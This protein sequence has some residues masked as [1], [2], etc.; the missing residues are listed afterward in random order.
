[1]SQSNVRDFSF[2]TQSQSFVTNLGLGMRPGKG[3]YHSLLGLLSN[4]KIKGLTF[5][6][7]NIIGLQTSSLPTSHSPSLLQSLHFTFVF[8][9]YDDSWVADIIRH[10]PHLVD[11]RLGV[12]GS[13]G[14]EVPKIDQAIGS[15]SKLAVLHR[16][17]LHEQSNSPSK[18]KNDTTPFGTVALRELVEFGLLYPPGPNG[19]LESAIRRSSDI[20]EVLILQSKARTDFNLVEA[21]GPLST[22]SN[23]SCLLLP[24]LTHL[25][26]PSRL[27]PASFELMAS[28]LPSLPLIH[29]HVKGWTCRLLA[30]VNLSV[31]KSLSLSAP[32]EDIVDIFS[33]AVL[34][35]S[36]YQMESLYL[37]RTLMTPSLLDVL[38][39]LPLK[40]LSIYDM[41]GHNMTEILQRLSLLHLQVLTIKDECY[42]WTVEKV[43]AGRSVEFLN[44]FLLQLVYEHKAAVGDIHKEDARDLN[45][46]PIRLARRRVRLMST[47]TFWNE[48]YAMLLPTFAH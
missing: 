27:T 17:N 42:D 1:T 46:S 32:E 24:R 19:L 34:K 8:Y 40:R 48:Y 30:F 3:R 21:L 10:C 14:S 33:R 11:M 4:T 35:S 47:M 37:Q 18:I 31:L 13:Q 12:P 44:G 15:L 38:G 28:I 43:L 23:Q 41:E 25:E 2:C 7:T 39:V 16:Y 29:L 5:T 6:N 26:L 20:L 9:L 45:G 36:S 22:A